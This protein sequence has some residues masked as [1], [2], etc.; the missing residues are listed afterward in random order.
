MFDRARQ[1]AG[2]NPTF[3]HYIEEQYST[4]L[5]QNKAAD[6]LATRGG[7]SAQQVGGTGA[8]WIR[9]IPFV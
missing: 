8:A 9:G 4:H 2:A 6:E 1:L 3:N 5:V 7:A